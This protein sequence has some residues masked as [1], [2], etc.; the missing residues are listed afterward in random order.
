[1][2]ASSLTSTLHPPRELNGERLHSSDKVS[3]SLL[4]AVPID[5]WDDAASNL[6]EKGVATVRLS[7]TTLSSTNT[8]TESAPSLKTIHSRAFQSARNALDAVLHSNNNSS[9]GTD[10]PLPMIAPQADSAHVTGFH[11]AGGMSRYNI[12]REGIVFSDD[13]CSCSEGNSELLSDLSKMYWSLHGIADR[14]LLAIEAQLELDEEKSATSVESG[15]QGIGWFQRHLGPTDTASQWH[16]KRFVIEEEKTNDAS[17]ENEQSAS[18][19][20]TET[21]ERIT[22]PMHTD[23]SLISIVI[24][25]EQHDEGSQESADLSTYE[26]PGA[27]GLQ[28]FHPKEK[29]WKEPEAHGHLVATVFVGSVLAHLTCGKYPAAKHRVVETTKPQGEENDAKKRMAATLFVRPQP[30]ALL[31]VPL[32]SPWLL[33][34]I[35]KEQKEIENDGESTTKKKSKRSVTKPPITFDAWLKRVAKNYEKQKKRQSN[36]NK[37][38]A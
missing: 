34:Q 26:A 9:N 16:M 35:E 38:T 27:L 13:Q 10:L 12:R 15:N 33:Q 25:D 8:T 14:V 17:V 21:G 6:L 36:K 18:T 7:T 3:S 1:M 2:K 23:P 22:L 5:I 30:S 4:D 31:Q 11:Y 20:R 28:Y 24:H 29:T 37:K 19:L 32:P